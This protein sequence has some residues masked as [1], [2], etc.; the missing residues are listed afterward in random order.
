MELGEYIYSD[1]EKN[2]YLISLY[3]NLIKKYAINI[4]KITDIEGEVSINVSDLLRF[5]DILSKSTNDLKK[6]KHNNI[7]QNIVVL[8]KELYPENEEVKKIYVSVLN[9]IR[10]YRGIKENN[11]YSTDIREFISQYIEKELYKIEPNDDENYFVRDQKNIYDSLQK[12]KFYSYSGP[13][14]MGKTFVIRKFIINQIKNN[15]KKNYVVV[16]PT[17]ALISEITSDFITELNSLLKEKNYKVI[18]TYSETNENDKY[19]YVMIYTQERLLSH[20]INSSIKVNYVF[21]DEAHKLFYKDTRTMYFYKILDILRNQ[22]NVPN[23]YFSAPLIKNPN[24]FLDLLPEIGTKSSSVFE[25]TP[26][27]QQKFMIDYNSKNIRIY[28]DLSSNFIELEYD[29]IEKFDINYILNQLGENRK[30]LV[31]CESKKE[32]I[33]YALEYS[34]NRKPIEENEYL[35]KVKKYIKDE[36]HEDYWLIDMLSKG[37]A[38]HIGYI[39]NSIRKH[40]ENL[41]KEKTIN[42]IFCTSTLLEGVNLP[43]DNLF[44]NVKD[45][46]KIISNEID[47]K[48]LI[49]RVGRIKY[50]LI[51]NVFIIPNGSPKLM[52]TCTELIENDVSDKE[53]SIKKVLS[54]IAKKEII[55][56]LKNGDTLIDKR[57]KTYD[58]Y[59]STRYIMNNLIDDIMNDRKGIIYKQFE[60]FITKQDIREIKEQ[61]REKTVPQDLPITTDQIDKVD[62]YIK[63]DKLEYPDKI[64]YNNVLTFLKELHEYYSWNI[65]EDKTTIGHKNNLAYYAVI[66]QQ[67]MLGFGIKQ[68]IQQAIKYHEDNNTFYDINFGMKVDYTGSLEQKNSIINETLNA[69]ENIILFK[70]SNYFS[71]FSSRYKEVNKIDEIAN[72]WYEYIQ[73]G[74]N[75]KIVIMIQKIG[76]SREAAL[77][78]NKKGYWILEEDKLYIKSDIF[79]D[80]D[81][82]LREEAK[83]VQL[84]NYYKFK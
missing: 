43:A 36:I 44:I 32:A 76:F 77:K 12:E 10:N 73:Y 34:K 3:T 62:K 45:K 74:T 41:Y 4:F 78:I 60:K 16:V 66:L 5:A 14:S 84:N 19:N 72:D 35:N 33:N 51:G 15:Y 6:Q 67:W 83:A 22:D 25:F 39:P 49:G 57:S 46:A 1:I 56:K 2:T 30:N 81:E 50:N 26:V 47:F 23:I 79:L 38:Y 40:I 53:L 37:V 18:N 71:K 24:E 9:N 55:N 11:Y 61:F 17:K 27:N 70:I 8:L 65:Y 42:T 58:E 13:T 48:N 54:T 82:L 31:Y 21:I 75:D 29:K 69:I 63:E 52:N 68:I 28:N 64:T 80:S 20:L 7:A 59:E